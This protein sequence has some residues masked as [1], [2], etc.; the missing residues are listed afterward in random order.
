VGGHRPDEIIADAD[1]IPG[2]QG[3]AKF[4]VAGA[5]VPRIRIEN[6]LAN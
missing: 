6:A 3:R 4:R 1:E 2:R 5:R